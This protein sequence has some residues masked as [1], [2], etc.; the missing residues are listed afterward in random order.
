M[1]SVAV[2]EQALAKPKSRAGASITRF[3]R[4]FVVAANTAKNPALEGKCP[5][6]GADLPLGEVVKCEYCK[7]LVNSG[8]TTGAGGNHAA[9]RVAG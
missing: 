9:G 6:C 4:L 7:A 1:L 2:A 8:N 5:S 3:G